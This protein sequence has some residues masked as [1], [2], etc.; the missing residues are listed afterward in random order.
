[1]QRTHVGFM[2]CHGALNGLRVASSFVEANPEARVLVSA[3]ELCT[4]HFHYGWDS[5]KI[6]AN[7]LFADGAGAVV[8]VAA[9]EESSGGA[10]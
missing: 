8:R 9:D 10:G 3:V 7:S 2:G 6:V 5:E 4:L 1:V